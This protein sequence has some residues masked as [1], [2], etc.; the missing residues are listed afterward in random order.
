MPAR[1]VHVSVDLQIVPFKNPRTGE[2]G[3]R[4]VKPMDDEGRPL[5]GVTLSTGKNAAKR[6]L[7][8]RLSAR[9]VKRR[10][11]KRTTKR[12]EEMAAAETYRQETRA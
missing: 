6:K 3:Y 10:D 5:P 4:A 2:I 1:Y 11:K 12:W 7:R 9:Q 8:A